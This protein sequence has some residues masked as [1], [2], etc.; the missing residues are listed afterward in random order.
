MSNLLATQQAR[1][2]FIAQLESIANGRDRDLHVCDRIT[3]SDETH[4]REQ[5]R[6]LRQLV[7]ELREVWTLPDE[8]VNKAGSVRA[9]DL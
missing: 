2:V 5:V 8:R 4:L 1:Q 6:V 7:V 9:Q 3:A